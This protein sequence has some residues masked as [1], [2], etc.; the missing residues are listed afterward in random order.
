M[1]TTLNLGPKLKNT[2]EAMRLSLKEA[3]DRLRINP[4]FLSMLEEENFSQALP[5]TFMKGYLRSYTRLLNF[6]ENE[7]NLAL[8]Q[9]SH[10]MP[11]L[12]QGK[13]VPVYSSQPK[14]I[15]KDRWHRVL[16]YLVV[17]T[18][19]LLVSMWWKSHNIKP[20]KSTLAAA[21]TLQTIAEPSQ[22]HSAALAPKDEHSVAEAGNIR[23]MNMAITEEP[24]LDLTEEE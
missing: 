7:I 13:I 17:F 4:K 8:N 6:T 2:R 3:A 24:G 14:S 1:N 21:S 10:M 15:K 5:L 16:T 12:A 18:L 11:E 9:L 22:E 19:I 20:S 23:P